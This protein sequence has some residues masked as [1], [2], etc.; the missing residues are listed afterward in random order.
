M[1]SSVT[2]GIAA[3]VVASICVGAIGYMLGL[4]LATNVADRKIAAM[5]K[6]YVDSIN[7]LY[8][9]YNMEMT[10]PIAPVKKSKPRPQLHIFRNDN[11][12]DDQP[13]T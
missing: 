1:F 12:K 7:G 5:R 8:Q 9:K 13:S 6:E 2:A 11:K 3:Y 4:V 10:A